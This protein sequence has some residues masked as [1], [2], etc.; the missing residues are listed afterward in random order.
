MNSDD[1]ARKYDRR[2]D[3]IDENDYVHI[4]LPSQQERIMKLTKNGCVVCY[5]R[6]SADCAQIAQLISAN[7][8]KCLT[9]SSLA[10]RTASASR[11]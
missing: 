11:S 1:I 2:C 8:A 4:R 10:S 6:G 5:A 3:F 9:V 7:S